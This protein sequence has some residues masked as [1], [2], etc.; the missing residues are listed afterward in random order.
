METGHPKAFISHATKDQER[1]VT[2]F[3][4]KLRAKGVDAWYAKWEMQPGDKLIGKIFDEGIG[5]SDTMIVVLSKNS[6]ESSWVREEMD[7]GFVRRVEKKLRRLI[8]VVI[9]DCEIPVALESTFQV[10]IRNL[11]SYEAE[12]DQIVAAIFRL[13]DI[14]EVGSVPA[15]TQVSYVGISPLARVDNF[16]LRLACEVA[17]ESGTSSPSPDRVWKRAE[18]LEISRTD[19]DDALL[20]L[21]KYRFIEKQTGDDRI[22]A[23]TVTIHGFHEYAKAYIPELESIRNAVIARIVNDRMMNSGDIWRALGQPK[24]IINYIIQY[25][26]NQGWIEDV[27]QIDDGELLIVGVLPELKRQLMD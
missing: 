7:T 12:L 17:I 8:P 3:A 14:P 18:L 24:V 27:R 19:F 25:F 4:Q 13:S 1:F 6:V 10:R 11:K 22:I 5:N 23:F 16:I 9:E 20:L 2:E 26:M 15:H 21:D